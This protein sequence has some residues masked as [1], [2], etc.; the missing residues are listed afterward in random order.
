MIFLSKNKF[1]PKHFK[2]CV[3]IDA[4]FKLKW[5]AALNMICTIVNRNCFRDA[6]RR[7]L[8]HFRKQ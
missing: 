1:A 5:P 7:W 4:A 2:S 8:W 3:K 6:S